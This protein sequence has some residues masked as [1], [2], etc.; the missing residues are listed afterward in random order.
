[1]KNTTSSLL[2]V[3]VT[4]ALVS[5]N[6]ALQ[7]VIV[8]HATASL[9]PTEGNEV[10]G[11]VSFIQEEGGVKI[12]VNAEGLTPGNHGFHIHEFGDCTD[13]KASSAGGALQPT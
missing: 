7:A 13:P 2:V 1:M 8:E 4:M 3:L 5:S 11:T 6:S 12:I 10:K 9:H